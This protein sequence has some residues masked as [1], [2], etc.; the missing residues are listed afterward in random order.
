MF[1]TKMSAV[2]RCYTKFDDDRNLSL[3]PGFISCAF[4]VEILRSGARRKMIH[5]L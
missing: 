5:G 2:S 1:A 3:F 4:G